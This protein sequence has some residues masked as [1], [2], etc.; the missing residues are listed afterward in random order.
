[1]EYQNVRA[2]VNFPPLIIGPWMLP[3]LCNIPILFFISRE[4]P[5]TMTEYKATAFA[6]PWGWQYLAKVFQKQYV[7]Q[8]N[9]MT[10]II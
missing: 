9:I 4:T 8:T 7:T 3:G 10:I 6:W 5:C 2:S 1:M